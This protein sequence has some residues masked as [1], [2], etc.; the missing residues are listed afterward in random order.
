MMKS[1]LPALALAFALFPPLPVASQTGN[2]LSLLTNLPEL[3][4]LSY[5]TIGRMNAISPID[6]RE[7][8]IASSG[9][10]TDVFI[11][12]FDGAKQDLADWTT[13]AEGFAMT[14]SICGA[15]ALEVENLSPI[16]SGTLYIPNLTFVQADALRSIWH[17]RETCSTLS[18][19]VF[20]V[21]Q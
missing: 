7:I 11:R 15:R 13:L 12:L 21:G 19:E 1:H 2:P 8:E 5:T 18:P 10:Q 14:V 16:T 3:P 17:G 4:M 20:P 6:V 9:D